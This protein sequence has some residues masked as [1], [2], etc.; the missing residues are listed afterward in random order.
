VKLSDALKFSRE[1]KAYLIGSI[2]G[3][4]DH[5]NLDNVPIVANDFG[6]EIEVALGAMQCFTAQ[7]TWS[8]MEPGDRRTLLASEDWEPIDPKPVMVIIAEA[9]VDWSIHEDE[10]QD[11]AFEEEGYPA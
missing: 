2:E 9:T 6:I 1:R 3:S 7:K 11:D 8:E 10:D 5:P 4:E